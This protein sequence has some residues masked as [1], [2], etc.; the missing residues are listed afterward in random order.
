LASFADEVLR[1]NARYLQEFVEALDVCPF[2]RATRSAGALDRQVV[3]LPRPSAQ[4]LLPRVDA[5]A[6]QG[7]E[8]GLIILPR[9][10]L[11]PAGLDALCNQLRQLDEAR[12]APAFAMA[13][14]HPEAPYGTDSPRRL[15][16]FFRRAPD[17]TIQLVRFS[18]LDAARAAAPGG[19]FLMQYNA[20]SLAEME[21]R[22]DRSLSDRIAAQNQ[23]T[24]TKEGLARLQAI[25]DDIRADR[26]RSYARFPLDQ[27]T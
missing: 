8:V 26:A 6:A 5:A 13:P 27:P 25:L 17:P 24:V 15:V 16:M 7:A 20:R 18:A 3:E 11:T 19:K 10:Q 21:K 2:A 22:I 4:D 9:A 23:A 1:I 12:G 14:F